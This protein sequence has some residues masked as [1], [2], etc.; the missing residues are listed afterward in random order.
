[1]RCGSLFS[2]ILT[3]LLAC[4]AGRLV[5]GLPA[6][7]GVWAQATGGQGQVNLTWTAVSGAASYQ[8]YYSTDPSVDALA[9]GPATALSTT[10]TV[11]GV[12]DGVT[13][14]FFVAP[15]DAGAAV[16]V[17]STPAVWGNPP[18]AYAQPAAPTLTA[19]VLP[20]GAGILVNVAGGV[21]AYSTGTTDTPALG[22]LQIETDSGGGFVFT[23]L[24][25]PEDLPL[26]LSAM[27][28]G[29]GSIP[30]SLVLQV[31]GLA[32]DSWGDSSVAGAAV[33]VT[34]T[35]APLLTALS[36]DG[37]NLQLTWSPVLGASGYL[38]ATGDLNSVPGSLVQSGGPTFNSA[39]V[40]AMPAQASP[41][42]RVY[43]LD[44]TGQTATA[45]NIV[46]QLPAPSGLTGAAL[47]GHQVWLVWQQSAALGQ[48]LTGYAVYRGT[49]AAPLFVSA[50]AAAALGVTLTGFTDGLPVAVSVAAVAGGATWWTGTASAAVELSSGLA[51][52]S[53]SAAGLSPTGGVVGANLQLTW[54]AVADPDPNATP[55]YQL[56]AYA[57]PEGVTDPASPL[58]TVR[59]ITVTAGTSGV[60]LSRSAGALSVWYGVAV[61][62]TAAASSPDPRLGSASSLLWAPCLAAPTLLSVTT[63]G[64]VGSRTQL[65]WA[66]VT[67]ATVYQVW[68]ATGAMAAAGLTATGASGGWAPLAGGLQPAS[69]LP[70]QTW[71]DLAALNNTADA[72]AVQA[73][74]LWTA[75]VTGEGVASPLGNALT[76]TPLLGP[77]EPGPL[78]NGLGYSLTVVASL[79]ITG[80][81]DLVWTPAGAGSSLV[82]SYQL[83]RGNSPDPAFMQPLATL[84]AVTPA[85]SA[86]LRYND[87][88]APIPLTSIFYA[89]RAFDASGKASPAWLTA[90]VGSPL[91]WG[92]PV[93]FSHLVRVGG[94][95]L[96]FGIPTVQ[97]TYGDLPSLKY[98][99]S[100]INYP[101]AVEQV[102]TVTS[103][104]G[105]TATTW[106][107]DFPEPFQG[108]SPLYNIRVLDP[109]GL[110]GPPLQIPVALVSMGNYLG[111]PSAVTDL[112]AS[113][114][115]LDGSRTTLPVTLSWVQNALAEEGVTQQALKYAIYANGL[116][117]TVVAGTLDGSVLSYTDLSGGGGTL[118]AVVTYTVQAGNAV[119]FGPASP[120]AVTLAPPQPSGVAISTL[121]ADDTVSLSWTDLGVGPFSNVDSYQVLRTSGG[122]TTTV[123]SGLTSP[124]WTDTSPPASGTVGYAVQS[125]LNGVASAQALT[126]AALTILPVPAAVGGLTASAGVDGARLSWTAVPS[127]DTYRIFRS[128]TGA[129]GPVPGVPPIAQ[130]PASACCGYVDAAAGAGPLWYAV[131]GANR[132]RLGAAAGV[133]VTAFPGP[134]QAL[135]AAAGFNGSVATVALTWTPPLQVG[136]ATGYNVYRASAAAALTAGG[137]APAAVLA[138]GAQWLASVSVT[139]SV[140]AG[141]N[142]NEAWYYGVSG[143]NATESAVTP[144]AGVATYLPLSVA[145]SALTQRGGGGGVTA[146]WNALDPSTGVNGYYVSLSNVGGVLNSVTVNSATAF[147]GLTPSAGSVTLS[148][149]GL[150]SAGVGPAVSIQAWANGARPATPPGGAVG[151]IGYYEA[152]SQQSRV[153]FN[154]ITPAAGTST[155]FYRSVVPIPLRL[156]AGG[157][158]SPL[159]LTGMATVGLYADR[160]VVAQQPYYYA[161][162]NVMD[163]PGL[164]GGESTPVFLG[165]LTPTALAGPC[166]LSG[167]A[168]NGRVDLQWSPPRG[169][170]S[171]GQPAP[172]A[173]A[174]L[175]YRS[176]SA[177]LPP[178]PVDPGFPV[179][180]GVGQTTYGDV[181]VSNGGAYY[182]SI[183][184]V[185]AAGKPSDQWAQPHQAP[186]NQATLAV[187]NPVWPQPAPK[188]L[189]ALA[190]NAQVTLRWVANQADANLG[191]TYNVYRRQ[192]GL[193]PSDYGA[194]AVLPWLQQVGPS[195]RDYTGGGAGQ[196]VETLSDPPASLSSVPAP[197]P[198]S[199]TFTYC[200][201]IAVVD[202]QGEGPRSAE[203]CASPFLPLAAP[204]NV[205][206]TVATS[207]VVA[208]TSPSLWIGWTGCPSQSGMGGYA[209]LGYRVYRSQD[210]GNNFTQ[211]GGLVLPP[212]SGS[213]PYAY[214]VSDTTTAFGAS[215]LYR[216]VGVDTQFNEGTTSRLVPAL[217]PTGD[218]AIHVY[219]NAFDPAR[220]EVLPVQYS[221][222]QNGHA[223]MKVYT[224]SGEYV[225]TLFDETVSGAGPQQPYLSAKINWDG[226]NSQGQTVASGV[227]LL[228]LEA[229]GYHANARVAV[230]K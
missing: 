200:Y 59:P 11:A 84:L 97:G 48:G 94:V 32:Y 62:D 126:Q 158:V 51:L 118:G 180:L 140:D 121:S 163:P 105:V 159:Y 229:P 64:A 4:L 74:L 102:L 101:G 205:S 228:H 204:L 113:I 193:G 128:S 43:A 80:T 136:D 91:P 45:S 66:T 60:D 95:S 162:T 149:Y 16:G 28:L 212:G 131:G 93:A 86:L 78:P 68:R 127:A 125:V 186:P 58:V 92:S 44:S 170:G 108:L 194:S 49:W 65:T 192:L 178:V 3:A 115:P 107:D 224:M 61:S 214:G 226:K 166:S 119:G 132:L 63:V 137:G 142:T 123:A 175:L 130:L 50:T 155:L 10:L 109:A 196:L 40:T 1:M 150:N 6:P 179:G 29:L 201:S 129:L 81:V 148:V 153:Q 210:G 207:A 147:L 18:W 124:Q 215:Y 206:V 31:R 164:P 69:G 17:T 213:S 167:T 70:T 26:T 190:G 96:G 76:I 191:G 173:T 54:T 38:V 216:V 198:P 219:R 223:W 12:P 165:P 90:T 8:V 203:V 187:M 202:G 114:G 21:G 169:W 33:S 112:A 47:P 197:G 189:T 143:F 36:G 13:Y 111:V 103:M 15:L 57:A 145:V 24:A 41:A 72:Y 222:Q 209:V 220:G 67:A 161:M 188:A 168:G 171:A 14:N 135:A 42:Y 52:P 230:I 177:A 82:T 53:F 9:V 182:Y 227:Y 217:I 25:A 225:T 195:A 174:Y 184:A 2:P 152:V 211:V 79:T 23:A 154:W 71:M 199:N 75:S 22:A 55:I 157:P 146:W 138:A 19:A 83:L 218:N 139:A 100:R 122:V 5:A 106:T 176:P 89:V 116:P 87:A 85:S 37:P 141:P 98:I 77:T 117:V 110:V 134:P 221:I 39:T 151:G 172:G 88:T 183:R 208:G 144:A 104:V 35:G 7:A 156:A 56:Y 185:D 73:L 181:A 133:S 20:Y 34:L 46:V 120:L 160:T 27:D 30:A 99:I